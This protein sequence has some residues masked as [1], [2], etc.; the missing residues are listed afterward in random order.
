MSG[1]IQI[2]TALKIP[3]ILKKFSL[4]LFINVVYVYVDVCGCA[5]DTAYSIRGQLAGVSSPLLPCMSQ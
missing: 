3:L 2:F 4:H 5:S 1:K